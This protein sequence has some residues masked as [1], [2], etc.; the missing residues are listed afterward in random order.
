MRKIPEMVE[1]VENSTTGRTG[2]PTRMEALVPMQPNGGGGGQAAQKTAGTANGG[3]NSNQNA[4]HQNVQ[5]SQQNG[6]R[7]N[8]ANYGRNNGG[9]GGG[10]ANDDKDSPSACRVEFCAR[11]ERNFFGPLRYLP[12]P[13]NDQEV[14]IYQ[15][16]Q[17]LYLLL[18]TQR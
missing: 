2:V 8:Y 15:G 16:K 14:G 13:P 9:G 5:K 4:N 18:E 6:Q 3:G 11:K 10:G 17:S 1:P 7:Q 12:Y